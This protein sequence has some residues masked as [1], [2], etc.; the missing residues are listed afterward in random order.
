MALVQDRDFNIMQQ[1]HGL[2]AIA[3]LLVTLC[4][5][6]RCVLRNAVLVLY[7]VLRLKCS[8]PET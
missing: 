5:L 2:C 3:K 8:S 7:D 6:R 4:V 1:S